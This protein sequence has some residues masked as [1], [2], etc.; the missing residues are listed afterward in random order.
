VAAVA[1]AALGAE[2]DTGRAM[3]EENVEAV[4]AAFAALNRRGVDE[5]AAHLTE[6]VDWRAMEGAPDD[7][8][9]IHGKDAMR[10]YVQDWLDMFDDVRWEPVELID[11]GGDRVI[12]VVHL[13]GRA[14]LS[15]VET[16]MDLR[17]RA[18][19]SRWEDGGWPRVREPGG[20]PRSRRAVGVA[21]R[22]RRD[23]DHRQSESLRFI[24]GR[25]E[26]VALLPRGISRYCVGDVGGDVPLPVQLTRG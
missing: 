9:P 23:L 20:R 11:A 5:L 19:D 24:C 21:A 13:T 8:G 14:K 26:A 18:H 12:A 10:A 1:V 7:H 2:R 22:S 4:K 3:S 17:G 25:V 16:D 6:D 15:G